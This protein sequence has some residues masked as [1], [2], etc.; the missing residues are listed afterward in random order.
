MLVSSSY[1]IQELQLPSRSQRKAGKSDSGSFWT[2]AMQLIQKLCRAGEIAGFHASPAHRWQL[3]P[4][5]FSSFKRSNAFFCTLKALHEQEAQ[6][7]RQ[8][9]HT[10]K[11]KIN[12]YIHIK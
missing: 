5:Y 10:H 2:S 7:Y 9:T 3:I 4:A 6:T 11:I 12:R 8:N 1:R